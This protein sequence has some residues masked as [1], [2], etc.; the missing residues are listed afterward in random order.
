MRTL[1]ELKKGD[2]TLDAGS[3]AVTRGDLHAVTY[4]WSQRRDEHGE[5]RAV[6]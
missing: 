1:T 5:G 3:S 6:D 4:S 2:I